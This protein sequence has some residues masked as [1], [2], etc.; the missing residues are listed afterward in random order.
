MP[1][2]RDKSISWSDCRTSCLCS[3]WF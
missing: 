3:H 2:D 1:S